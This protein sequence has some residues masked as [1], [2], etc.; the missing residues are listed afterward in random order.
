MV[1]ALYGFFARQRK[2]RE[3]SSRKPL[4]LSRFILVGISVHTLIQSQSVNREI[5]IRANTAIL[6]AIEMIAVM[7][8]AF[9]K[10]IDWLI[11]LPLNKCAGY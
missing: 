8:E 3:S 4:I 11:I 2:A 5:P 6:K 10:D 7:K 9:L 1:H